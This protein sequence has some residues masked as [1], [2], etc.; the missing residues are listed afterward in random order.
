MSNVVR[1]DKKV[2]DYLKREADELRALGIQPVSRP[3]ALRYL[4]EKYNAG[5]MFESM[6]A[7]RK[8]R[9]KN[10]IVINLK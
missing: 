8:K 9:N 4:I 2:E 5:K 1:F 10:G 6:K 7:S 3:M